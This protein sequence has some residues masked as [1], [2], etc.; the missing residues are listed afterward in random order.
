MAGGGPVDS[1]TPDYC[2]D[3]CLRS[4]E[5][6]ESAVRGASRAQGDVSVGGRSR[7]GATMNRRTTFNDARPMVCVASGRVGQRSR[8]GEVFARDR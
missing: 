2:S 1:E 5:F 7:H 3:Y 4:A 8:A 6:A